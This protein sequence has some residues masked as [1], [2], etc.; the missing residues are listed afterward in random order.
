MDKIIVCPI[1]NKEIKNSGIGRHFKTKHNLSY[2]EYAKENNLAI[3][4]PSKSKKEVIYNETSVH[5]CEYDCGN[6]A[7]YQL[8]NGK[9][10]CCKSPNSCNAIRKKNSESLR[11]KEIIWKNGH[12]K[13]YKNKTGWSKGLTKDTDERVKRISISLKTKIKKGEF[14]TNKGLKMSNEFKL[15]RRQEMLGR[16]SNGF[17]VKCGRAPKYDYESPVAGNIKV[18]GSWE[19]KV[20]QYLDIIGYDWIR[21]KKRF[22][23]INELGEYST[24]CPDFYIIDFDCYIE[25]K[26]YTTKK[27]ICKW[28]QFTENL[29]VWNKEKLRELDIL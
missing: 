13:G 3:F 18:D 8:K 26:G 1:C 21:N 9:W 11:N 17:E 12:P 6:I 29:R 14:K 28:K 16:Y 10:C 19:L 24:Y 5:T 25:V 15:K 20:A 4:K 7:K 22:E 27:D 23:Y 2:T